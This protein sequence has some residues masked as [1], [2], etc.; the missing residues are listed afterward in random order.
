[1][2]ILLECS[3]VGTMGQTNI[4]ASAAG[5]NGWGMDRNRGR[6]GMGCTRSDLAE[7]QNKPHFDVEERRFS[8]ALRLPC[9]SGL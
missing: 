2:E 8:A 6:S 5:I 4:L 7:T 1:M 3:A 9:R